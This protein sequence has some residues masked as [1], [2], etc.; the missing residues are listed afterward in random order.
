MLIGKTGR[1]GP[2][3]TVHD[4]LAGT[5]GTVILHHLKQRDERQPSLGRDG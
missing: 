2:D 5:V 1:V 4:R 3:E